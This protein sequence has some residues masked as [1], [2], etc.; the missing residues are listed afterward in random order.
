MAAKL[1]WKPQAREDLFDIYC[2]IGFDNPA[3]A[4]RIVTVMESSIET[5]ATFPRMGSSRP[6]IQPS[7]RIL[8]EAPYLILYRIEP[9]TDHEPVKT[10]EIIRIVDGRRDLKTLLQEG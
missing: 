1:R 8:V 5:L 9:D 10:V 4:E 3:A 6:D 2:M 7:M